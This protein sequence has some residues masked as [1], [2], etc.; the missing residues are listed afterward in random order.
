MDSKHANNVTDLSRRKF[1][2][3][4]GLGVGAAA[5]A[6]LAAAACEPRDR[7]ETKSDE[8][9]WWVNETFE[10]EE[11]TFT[12]LANDMA[13]GRRTSV[14]ITQLYLDRI[15]A[16]DRDGAKLRSIIETNGDA[17]GIATR[18]DEERVNGRVRSPLHGIP[19]V[20]K[21]N[22]DTADLMTTT[23]G[24][25]ALEGHIA[26]EDSSVAAKLREAG[27]IILAKAN[28]S[29]WA[30]IRSSRSSSG[31]SGRGG[32]C[33][34]AFAVDR[35]PCGSSSGSGAAVSANF[36]AGA[37]GTETNGSV[38]CPSS[39]NGVVGLKP[40][41][42]L[43]SRSG[44]I[45][46]SHTQDTAGPMTRSITDAAAMLTALVGPDPRDP[47]STPSAD[48]VG[49]DYTSFLDEDGLRGARIGVE[50][51]YFG[52]Q[53]GV[54]QLMEDAILSMAAAGA[55]I[56][57]PANISTRVS[58][59]APSFQVLLYELKADLAAYLEMSGRPNG[60]ATLADIIAF[61]EVDSDREMPYFGQE[62]FLEAE[63]KG[64][65][66]SS[67]YL[68]SKELARRLSRDEGID[69]LMEE[70]QLDAIVAPTTRPAWKID[71]VNRDVSSNGS[72]G[73]AAIAGY[74]SIT[75][76]NGYV[77]GLPAGILFFGR[78]WSEGVLIRIAYAYE[79]AT[80]HR[81]A[82]KLLPTLDLANL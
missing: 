51:S 78:A 61:N 67:E 28:L 50:R 2:K 17:L 33:G 79:Q 31:W 55:T 16:L 63:G 56:V 49:T 60:M 76:P 19:I 15:A 43:V 44:I 73:P 58:M 82:A 23:A 57:D 30:N 6:A 7:Q 39:V 20:L 21:D 26:A 24:S 72:S 54:D 62:T 10:L 11:A 66:T 59:G 48:F 5:T 69:A 29:E 70:H 3:L 68:V 8:R 81:Q 65:L 47:M 35:N 77:H 64:P 40:T 52:A 27:A 4:G 12:S 71:L 32:Q 45:P 80:R 1:V 14:E 75:V 37:I 34:N 13:S 25:Y 22:I 46:I 18:L 74:P 53:P 36:C 42:G 41:V 9:P 38:V